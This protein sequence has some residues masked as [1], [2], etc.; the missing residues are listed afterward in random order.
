MTEATVPKALMIE[1][2]QHSKCEATTPSNVR[3]YAVLSQGHE[4]RYTA[5][6]RLRTRGGAD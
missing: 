2:P 3:G 5:C 4:T 1:V 6:Y